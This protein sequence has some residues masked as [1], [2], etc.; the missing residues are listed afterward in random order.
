MNRE[1]LMPGIAAV[2]LAALFPL[3]W[4]SGLFSTSG[5]TLLEM[6]K[7]DVSSLTPIDGLF[8]LIGALEIYIY[9]SLRRLLHHQ[10]QGAFAAGMALAMA[11]AVGA[12]TSIVLFD[13]SLALTPGMAESAR[14]STILV[15]AVVSI[16]LSVLVGLIGIALSIALLALRNDGTILL[17]IFAG[18]LL[19]CSLMTITIL[20]APVVYVFYPMALV[21]LA[22]F[23]LRG[24]GE[25]EVV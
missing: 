12:F 17:K 2:A 8:V 21:I 4:F 20:L 16:G 13:V 1:F 3:Y 15:A 6:Y 9:L 11:I 23:F 22:A 14:Q 25:V 24:G 5:E 18:L 10:L 7:A 19:I